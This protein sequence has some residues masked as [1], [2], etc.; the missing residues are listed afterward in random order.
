MV[1]T[2]VM[3][4]ERFGHNKDVEK[5]ILKMFE[6]NPDMA[7]RKAKKILKI[8]FNEN[9]DF[10]MA[11]IPRGLEYVALELAKHY[12]ENGELDKAEKLS[13]KIIE[14]EGATRSIL[15]EVINLQKSMKGDNNMENNE[16]ES[17]KSVSKKDGIKN[18]NKEFLEKINTNIGGIIKSE[19]MEGLLERASYS[20]N[21][22]YEDKL[23]SK[24]VKGLQE[25][26]VPKENEEVEA[27]KVFL[28]L[29][30]T[31]NISF[32]NAGI[33]NGEGLT[34]VLNETLQEYKTGFSF[35][36]EHIEDGLTYKE[37]KKQI[38]EYVK[39]T[40]EQSQESENVEVEEVKEEI[41]EESHDV[42]LQE[43]SKKEDWITASSIDDVAMCMAEKAVRYMRECE[44]LSVKEDNLNGLIRAYDNICDRS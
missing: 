40:H 33:I 25:L 27:E 18:E 21:D 44:K 11:P 26:G 17:K 43:K 42:T 16:L 14:S 31:K 28:Y 20:F 37:L 23:K 7:M 9:G 5:Y 22:L 29:R 24:I 39:N 13:D 19:I 32:I 34:N 41:L 8:Q 3:N 1:K 30:M 38:K 10:R 15:E 36:E 6:D 2:R 12:F 35:F 4:G